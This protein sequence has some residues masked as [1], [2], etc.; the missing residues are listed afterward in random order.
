MGY[1]KHIRRA[2]PV[3]MLLFTAVF[4]CGAGAQSCSAD[5]IDHAFDPENFDT[6]SRPLEGI[7]EIQEIITLRRGTDKE[8]MAP[9]MF[10]DDI[11]LSKTILLDSADVKAIKAIPIEKHPPYYSLE[12]KLTERGR[13]HWIG[14]SL[15]NRA[16]HI[17]FIIDGMVYRTFVPRLLYDDVTDSVIV[18]GPFDPATAKKLESNSARNYFRLK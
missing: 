11:C 10:G 5:Q 7:I 4:C 2:L 13:R 14:L 3:V 12:L 15:P 16:T 6:S 8:V 17:A 18:D 9:T 1:M